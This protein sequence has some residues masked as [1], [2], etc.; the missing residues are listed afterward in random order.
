[1]AIIYNDYECYGTISIAKLKK[2]KDGF[3]NSSFG[4][5]GVCFWGSSDDSQAVGKW[6]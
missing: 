2:I 6:L 3:G 5:S 4:K 1:M